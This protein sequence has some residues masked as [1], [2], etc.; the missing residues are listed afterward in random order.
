VEKE[1][2]K[3]GIPATFVINPGCGPN[4]GAANTKPAVVSTNE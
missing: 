2:Y 4:C 3:N 1:L